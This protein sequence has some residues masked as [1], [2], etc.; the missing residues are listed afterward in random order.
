M[1]LQGKLKRS[2]WRVWRVKKVIFRVLG[3]Q[4]GHFEGFGVK[5][6]MVGIGFWGRSERS[7]FGGFWRVP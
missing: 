4:K 5:F 3:G 1:F 2:F 7:T 6:V